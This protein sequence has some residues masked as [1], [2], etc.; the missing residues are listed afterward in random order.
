MA[1]GFFTVAVV[2]PPLVDIAAT[3]AKLP[4]F[5]ARL[6]VY[7]LIFTVIA[8]GG[9]AVGNKLWLKHEIHLVGAADRILGLI[10]GHLGGALLAAYVSILVFGHPGFDA[11]FFPPENQLSSPL[12]WSG[13]DPILHT[14][15]RAM[16]VLSAFDSVTGGKG[17]HPGIE[18]ARLAAGDVGSDFYTSYAEVET[19]KAQT[20]PIEALRAW[21]RFQGAYQSNNP[22]ARPW[23]KR[24]V[25]E[26]EK[27]RPLMGE[28]DTEFY[29]YVNDV[30]TKSNDKE[31]FDRAL[32]DVEIFF[33]DHPRFQDLLNYRKTLEEL[34][35]LK[36]LAERQKG[37][38][39]AGLR[40]LLAD[41]HPRSPYRPLIAVELGRLTGLAIGTINPRGG[42]TTF[43][44]SGDV[45][46][47]ELAL[48]FQFKKA[49]EVMREYRQ[50]LDG[51]A[52]EKALDQVLD[53]KDLDKLHQA[54]VVAIGTQ[55][56][57][58]LPADSGLDGSLQSATATFVMLKI[59]GKMTGKSWSQLT[60]GQVRRIY[61]L[62][63]GEDAK[64]LD[65]FDRVMKK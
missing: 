53:Y 57:T 1:F 47:R 12:N 54:A 11:A 55:G 49:E 31:A 56:E 41:E 15:Y 20:D 21:D 30:L 65:V 10:F 4:L 6:V 43:G 63:L 29:N 16:Q 64:G 34:Q 8:C 61:Q 3:W 25:T 58:A 24:A 23:L 36:A 50:T 7:G 18:G 62:Y 27:L 19:A 40:K 39:I 42:A 52:K 48:K 37:A 38:A 28:K 45:A 9:I 33:Q 32:H 14:P 13:P 60:P 26:R 46:A 59:D 51:E 35:A 22:E 5:Q 17:F 2:G 44:R